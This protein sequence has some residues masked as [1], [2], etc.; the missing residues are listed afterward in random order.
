MQNFVSIRTLNHFYTKWVQG[1]YQLIGPICIQCFLKTPQLR[2]LHF[3]KDEL[4][5]V[6]PVVRHPVLLPSHVTQNYTSWRVTEQERTV[7]FKD[8]FWAKANFDHSF[9]KSYLCMKNGEPE[10]W[11]FQL[12]Y[13]NLVFVTSRQHH[14]GFVIKKW[15]AYVNTAYMD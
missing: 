12:D 15:A 11:F 2:S 9:Y 5:S 4:L 14:L 8:F 13:V 7:R 10:K 6:V 3:A 1:F